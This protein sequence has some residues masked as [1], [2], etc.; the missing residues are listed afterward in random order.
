MRIP[1]LE[2]AIALLTLCNLHLWSLTFLQPS[3]HALL[4]I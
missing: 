2:L 3:S 4:G 1:V